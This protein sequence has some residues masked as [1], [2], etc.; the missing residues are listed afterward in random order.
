MSFVE[1]EYRERK[2]SFDMSELQCH[3]HY[4]LYFLTEGERCF[5]YEDRMFR[6][7]GGSFCI[8]PP[9]AMHKTSGG[10][11][12]RINVNISAELLFPFERELLQRLCDS[13]AFSFSRESLQLISAILGEGASVSVADTREK[14]AVVLSYVHAL[15]HSLSKAVYLPISHDA[16]TASGAVDTL[17]LKVVSYLNSAYR[18][19]LDL[20]G[21]SERFYISKN[22]L[23][24]RFRTAMSCSVMEYISFL[25]LGRAKELLRT[26]EKSMSEI[27]SL[28]G[29]SSANY[30]S[31]I[32][33]RSVGVSP[34]K[35]RKDG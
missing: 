28:C 17:I 12:K 21:I 18:D 25:R 14:Q 5:F 15:L 22:T 26:T 31:L 11:Y 6:L 33:K 2:D 32:F 13:T 7:S 1:I 3:D 30:F 34:C 35:Y 29:Y 19:E 9:F 8:I 10:A 16:R 27:A 23:C 20:G 24:A 4:E